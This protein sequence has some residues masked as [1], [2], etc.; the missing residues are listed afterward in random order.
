MAK[1][2][3]FA[4][5]ILDYAN[6][7]KTISSFV[8]AVRKTVGQY[9]GYN[10]TRGHINMIREI[11]QNGF[12]E[13][14]KK[15]SPCDSLWLEYDENTMMCKVRDNGRGIPF[16]NI[17]RVFTKQHTSSN[18][19]KKLGEY[20]SGRH[21][22]GSKVTNACSKLFI[23]ESYLYTG[24]ARKVEFNDGHPWKKGEV[25]I[26]N[27]NKYQGSVI[28]F[29]PSLDVMKNLNTTC[30]DVLH[31]AS[32]I[33]Y[34][35]T[36]GV[37][38]T[39]YFRG[40]KKDGSV[41]EE[42]LVNQDGIL[43]FLIAKCENPVV[44]PIIIKHDNGTIKCEIAFTYDSKCLGEE[45]DIISFANMCPTVNGQSEHVKGF[46]NA[47][48]NYF[49]NYMNKIYLTKGKTKCI[50]SDIL[51][52]MKAVVTV[53]HLEPIFSGQAKEIFSGEGV[54]AF[55]K[56]T[57]ESQLDEWCKFN[58]ND[59]Q[60]LC[61]YYKDTADLR[62]SEE[63]NKTNF[64]KRVKVS[65]FGLPK[66][67]FPPAGKKNL[68]LIIAEG[69]SAV[70]S[71]KDAIDP[72]RQGIFPIRGKIINAFT[73]SR[74]AIMKNEEVCGIAAIIG[75]GI[76]KNFDI[77]KCKFDKI[78]FAGDADPDGKNIR[79]LLMKLFL[80]YFRPLIEDGRVYMAQPPLYSIIKNK[81]KVFFTDK[82]DYTKFL[83]TSFTNSYELRD[84]KKKV[85]KNRDITSMLYNNSSYIDEL[86]VL[87]N[88]YAIDPQLLEFLIRYRKKPISWMMKFIKSKYRFMDVKNMN[89]TL[90][91]DGLVGEQFYNIVCTPTLYSVCA[92]LY[93][94]IDTSLELYYLNKQPA[95]LYDVMMAFE[96]F[97]PSSI[98]RYKGLGE[99]PAQDLRIST[100]HPN[101][102]RALLQLTVQD[103][104]KQIQEIRD[105]QSNLSC[106]LED[107]DMASF[108]F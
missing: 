3:E 44:S 4:D 64:I 89:G 56:S 76:G 41:I 63:S 103:I 53:S 107:V 108:E 37:G 82:S 52:G 18:Y 71:L 85:I 104:K 21:G 60:R 16:N 80:M 100:I 70:S 46:I 54:E 78:I 27:P 12:D 99:M 75:C 68:E 94:Y 81:K 8:D 11:I 86:T 45:A 59:L 97:R 13:M 72:N 19:V 57:L 35:T 79:Q 40:V 83:Q 14:E 92:S 20:S 73:N 30:E 93:Q 61:K 34:L 105:I 49:R 26:P 28:T 51:S 9:L 32:T 62:M 58:A 95:T 50:G 31:L 55:I 36:P 77:S 84:S 91:L 38:N 6:Q 88:T 43:S 22:V 74:E 67:Y 1:A 96:R 33:L 101:Y 66:K 25:K 48:S 10:D 15:D 69:D 24:D 90:V 47:L 17:E 42:T 7:I 5:Q 23:A 2:K 106:L 39:L 102:D 29:I 65:A 98:Q 87:A